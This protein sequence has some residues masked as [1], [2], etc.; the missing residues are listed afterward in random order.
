MKLLRVLILIL[1]SE[2]GIAQDASFTYSGSMDFPVADSLVCPF[3]C[4]V[5]SLNNLWIVSTNTLETSAEHSVFMAAA[6]D[7][8]IKMM[9]KFGTSD[10]VRN[11]T[12]ITSIGKDIFISARMIA[13]AGNQAPDYYPYSQMFYLPEGDPSKVKVFKRPGFS[14]Y[15][16]W[17]TSIASTKDG[18]I[19]FGQSY[20]VTIGSIDGR[21][22]SNAFGNSIDYARI[23]WGTSME[24]G[25]GLTYPNIMDLIRDVAVVPSGD[26]SDS[27][28]VVYTSRNSSADPGGEATG[29]IAIWTG[30]SQS[31]PLNYR[32][33]RLNDLSG[34]LTFTA[35]APYG[36]SVNPADNSLFVCGTDAS[37]KWVKGFQVAG[38]FAIQTAEL[39]GSTSMDVQ[40][41]NGAPFSAPTDVAF[42]RD[43][44][45]AYV[46]DAGTK[47]VYAFKKVTSDILNEFNI[48]EAFKVEQNYPNPFNPETKIAVTIPVSSLLNAEVFNILGEKIKILANKQVSSGTHILN[49]DGSGLPSGI[50]FCKVTAGEYSR[51]IKM[52]LSK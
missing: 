25:G 35:S 34:F 20:L 41:P 26:Y 15:G 7:T 29:G 46:T 1:L 9:I 37:K 5:D 36:I 32:S 28:A 45:A 42:N 16:T 18:Y 48:V 44:Q 6:G 30:G 8:S 22:V 10:S 50:Y 40:D 31:D 24:P 11:I 21:K 27:S 39:P 38:N 43:G 33:V 13:P 47:K 52:N 51:T 14:D 12:G 19:Y 17:Y 2:C 23:D 49:F 3:L 4:T